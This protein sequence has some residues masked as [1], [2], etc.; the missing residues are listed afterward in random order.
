[1]LV[2]KMFREFSESN[3]PAEPTLRTRA[4]EK[5]Y[6]D[7][8]A[9]QAYQPIIHV[10]R[11]EIGLLFVAVVSHSEIMDLTVSIITTILVLNF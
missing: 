10:P 11:G 8:I 7:F 4:R 1:M 6:P 5:P 2:E 9:H 3:F